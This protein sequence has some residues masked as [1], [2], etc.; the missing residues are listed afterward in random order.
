MSFPLSIAAGK[1]ATFNVIFTPKTVGALTGNVSVVSD[2]S[3]T[4]STVSLS[5]T[6][7]AATALLTTS[8]NSLS[9]GTITIGKSSV[10]SVT[11]TNAGN[12]SITVSKVTASGANYAASGVSAGL[13]LTPGQSA[14]L[15]ETFTPTAAASE[16]GSVAVA[17]NASNS[18]AAISLSGAGTQ[19]A[20]H[21]VSLNWT[22]STSVVAGYDVFRSQASGGPYTK[23]DS[24]AVAADSYVDTTV[25]SGQTYYYVVAS[26]TSA[27]V[28][29]ADSTQASATIPTP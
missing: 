7:T 25:Q 24:S 10:L 16:A 18:P 8:T 13:V 28:E 27:G 19:T 1:Q 23:L 22:P 9:F 14:T 26:V 3:S 4:P 20:A 11:L 2:A 5:G 21:S 12:S 29:S 15:E 6:G 17:S